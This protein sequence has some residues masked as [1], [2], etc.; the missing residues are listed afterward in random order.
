MTCRISYNHPLPG[1]RRVEWSMPGAS[2]VVRYEPVLPTQSP[3]RHQRTTTPSLLWRLI[4]LL[5]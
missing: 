3:G 5:F 1:Y 2:T 4:S